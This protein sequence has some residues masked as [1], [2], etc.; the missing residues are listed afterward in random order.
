MF[1]FNFEVTLK[2]FLCLVLINFQNVSEASQD[3][4]DPYIPQREPNRKPHKGIIYNLFY[5]SLTVWYN[6]NVRY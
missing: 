5:Y 4:T 6:V 2:T 1:V 3:L